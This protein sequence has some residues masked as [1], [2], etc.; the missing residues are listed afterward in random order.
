M[1]IDAHSHLWLKQDAVVDGQP[2]QT[3]PTNGSRSIFFGEEVQMLPP[4]MIDGINSA[5]IFLSNMDYA[6]VGGA[7]VVQEVID[8]NQNSYLADKGDKTKCVN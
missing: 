6:Q 3:L 4:F 5:E 1:I 8:G 7:V 2:I